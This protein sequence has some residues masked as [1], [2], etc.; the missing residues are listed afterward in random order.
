ME[1]SSKIEHAITLLEMAL[2]S[3]DQYSVIHYSRA[4]TQRD[5]I[6]KALK[7]LKYIQKEDEVC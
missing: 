4:W 5:R 6:E 2:I 3:I 7:N 1:T